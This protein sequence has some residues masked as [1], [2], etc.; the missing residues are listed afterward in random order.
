M[1]KSRKAYIDTAIIVT[2][3]DFFEKKSCLAGI[4]NELYMF[5]KQQ[6]NSMF[7]MCVTD[8]V[9]TEIEW[10]EKTGE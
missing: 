7:G 2:M 6:L 3:L 1:Y 4:D 8:I 5:S 9:N 10:Q